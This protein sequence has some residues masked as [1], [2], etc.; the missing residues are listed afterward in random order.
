MYAV[1]HCRQLSCGSKNVYV[2][3]SCRLAEVSGVV[4]VTR[5][6]L[7]RELHLPDLNTS[8]V[9]R[10]KDPVLVEPTPGLTFADYSKRDMEY[11]GRGVF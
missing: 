8:L 5:K 9:R 1:R 4:S 3:V 11:A 2:M 7:N 10:N 6:G